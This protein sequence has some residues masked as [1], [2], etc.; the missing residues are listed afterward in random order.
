MS[1]QFFVSLDASSTTSSL[2]FRPKKKKKPSPFK[3]PPLPPNYHHIMQQH[4]FHQHQLALQ[5]EHHRQPLDLISNSSSIPSTSQHQTQSL[6]HFDVNSIYASYNPYVTSQSLNSAHAGHVLNQQQF[7]QH[8]S[9]SHCPPPISRRPRPPPPPNKQLPSE[10]QFLPLQVFSSNDGMHPLSHHHHQTSAPAPATPDHQRPKC[11]HCA[12]M[13]IDEECTEA[14]GGVYHIKCFACS[15]CRRPLGGLQY[16]MHPVSDAGDV[17]DPYCTDCFD[18]LFGEYCEGCGQLIHVAKGAAITHE[19]RSWHANECC[20]K[21]Q[22][23]QQS[24]LGLPFLPHSSGFIFCSINCS[25]D[26]FNPRLR[27]SNNQQQQLNHSSDTGTSAASTPSCI[28]K[29]NDQEDHAI[30]SLECKKGSEM[31]ESGSISQLTRIEDEATPPPLPS[32]SPSSGCSSSNSI[33]ANSFS[34]LAK[35]DDH[36]H[37]QQHRPELESS[38]LKQTPPPVF[39]TSSSS[40]KTEAEYSSVGSGRG[41]SQALHMSSSAVTAANGSV[42]GAGVDDF[43]YKRAIM[44]HPVE[45]E[46]LYP[47]DSASSSYY[48]CIGSL[49]NQAVIHPH[50]SVPMPVNPSSSSAALPAFG[51]S[52]DQVADSRKMMTIH[53]Q[54]NQGVESHQI[55]DRNSHPNFTDSDYAKHSPP[56]PAPSLPPKSPTIC[57]INSES[58]VTR[59]EGQEN[60]AFKSD[61]ANSSES[62]TN[63]NDLIEELESI[64]IADPNTSKSECC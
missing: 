46:G 34:S 62:S 1:D 13:I 64:Q 56:S 20:F 15:S 14:E 2:K 29:N 33:Q 26:A 22:N 16:I 11:S 23:C 57:L 41:S 25:K 17:R 24:L 63:K 38:S 8:M 52:E 5:H 55:K 39:Q 51:H 27:H 36:H 28:S 7:Q 47:E 50:Q 53:A 21:C 49:F 59:T 40:A 31:R 18:S 32:L 58:F 4:L 45:E 35:N 44:L 43:S 60:P 10:T 6:D 61:E 30:E 42:M 12:S 48:A 54:Q 9:Q 37:H 3:P 19:G